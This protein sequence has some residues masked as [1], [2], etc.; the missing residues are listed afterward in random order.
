MLSAGSNVRLYFI[1]I[2]LMNQARILKQLRAFFSCCLTLEPMPAWKPVHYHRLA[3]SWF[4]LCCGLVFSS[5]AA[6]IPAIKDLFGLNEASLGAVLFM[7]P[8]GSFLALPIAGWAVHRFGSRKI[9]ALSAIGYALQLVMIGYCR[10]VWQLS[11]VLFLFGFFGDFLNISMNTQGLTVQRMID[12]PVLSGMHGLWSVGALLGAVIGGWSL[13]LGWSTLQHLA[14]V[15]IASVLLSIVFYGW[16]VTEQR[17]VGGPQKIFVRP[18][19]A[20][21]MLGLICFCTAV[22][23]G[24]MADWSSLY[25]RQVLRDPGG[26]STTGYTAFTFAMAVGRLMGDRI[27]LWLRYKKTL[28]L[29]GMCIALGLAL[30][31][32][33]PHPA[34]VIAGYALVGI[35]VSVVI[36]IV[37]MVA[38]KS[39]KMAPAA[40][41]AAV[42]TVGFTGFLLGPPMIGF[43]AHETGLRLALVTVLFLGMLITLLAWRGV[44]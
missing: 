29:N 34:T 38:G 21:L 42:S 37:Y 24:A 32:G 39:G 14:W 36:P 11:A 25:Y 27:I 15:G 17:P 6:R 41:L 23:E 3:V 22:C 4:F 35:G 5:W 40:A 28:M 26:V 13:R 20:L 18:E 33:I 8:F 9:T 10:E 19:P 1:R 16:L 2:N 7:L 31:L 44:K 12:R 43:I 30:A